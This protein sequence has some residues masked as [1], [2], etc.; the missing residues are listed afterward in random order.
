MT[1]PTRLMDETT[2]MQRRRYDLGAATAG[3][4]FIGAGAA[5]LLDR[6]DAIHLREGAV[7]PAVVVGLG[8][9]LVMSSIQR[10]RGE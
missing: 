7:L 4:V 1:T 5:F 8:L 3:L 10:H 9:A 2:P 6:L